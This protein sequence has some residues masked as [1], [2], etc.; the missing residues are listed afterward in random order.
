MSSEST[1]RRW[2]CPHTGHQGSLFE[3]A[4]SAAERG[5]QVLIAGAGGAAHLPGLAASMTHREI[6]DENAFGLVPIPSHLPRFRSGGCL[7]AL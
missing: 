2:W 3:Y 6:R 1:T 4:G 7:W 5:L